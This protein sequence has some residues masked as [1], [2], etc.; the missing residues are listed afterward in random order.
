MII[1]IPGDIFFLLSILCG[2]LSFSSHNLI[3]TDHFG[4]LQALPPPPP[5]THTLSQ[6]HPLK[7]K[8]GLRRRS[9][10]KPDTSVFVCPPK[11]EDC[12]KR[13]VTRLLG[14]KLYSRIQRDTQNS[15]A[16]T[17][18]TSP[19]N[20]HGCQTICSI[21]TRTYRKTHTKHQRQGCRAATRRFA[22]L[23]DA[24]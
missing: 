21:S 1:I 22:E 13:N 8:V 5:P 20:H 19:H 14:E 7:L 6:H 12:S 17:H 11:Y 24:S 15:K 16:L 18:I 4:G 9:N 2:N 3:C 10:K 23:R